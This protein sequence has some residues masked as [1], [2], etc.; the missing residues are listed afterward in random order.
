MSHKPPYDPDVDVRKYSNPEG[1]LTVNKDEETGEYIVNLNNQSEPH[2]SFEKRIT[3]TRTA[4]LEGEKLWA[5]PENWEFQAG[6]ESRASGNKTEVYH[7][8][9]TGVDVEVSV[10]QNVHLIDADYYVRSVGG[11]EGVSTSE[12]DWED[13]EALLE[14]DPDADPLCYIDDEVID[15]LES[16]NKDVKR[17]SFE[18]KVDDEVAEFGMDSVL[19]HF[20]DPAYGYHK[21]PADAFQV[22]F[23][24]EYALK[25]TLKRHQDVVGE[26]EEVLKEFEIVPHYPQFD[27]EIV[28]EDSVEY[29]LE[30]AAEA[31]LSGSEALD[32]IMV[33]VLDR[34]QSEWAEQRGVEQ[35]TVSG[36]VASA[37]RVIQ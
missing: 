30:A 16:L 25:E 17:R 9:E 27:Y 19:E 32:Y 22:G 34:S 36:N 28:S 7:I 14:L 8:P 6:F 10:P 13:L 21:V 5:I 11:L 4:V 18:R 26:V 33:E 35:G 29:W 15:A 12:P 23:N 1:S 24:Y 2:L 3:S 37:K 31:G 20:D